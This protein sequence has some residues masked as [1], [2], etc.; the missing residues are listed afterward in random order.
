MV[1]WPSAFDLQR[2]SAEKLR[3]SR[4]HCEQWCWWATVPP[5]LGSISKGKLQISLL[6]GWIFCPSNPEKPDSFT[7]TFDPK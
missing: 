2:R 3:I 1:F 7:Q 5:E 6:I 4:S